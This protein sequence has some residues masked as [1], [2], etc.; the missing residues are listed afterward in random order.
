M[1][2]QTALVPGSEGLGDGTPLRY[3]K[4]PRGRARLTDQPLPMEPTTMSADAIDVPA[5]S[6]ER[7]P[8][9]LYFLFAT[10]MWERFGFYTAAAIMTLYLQ[11]GGFGWTKDQ[12]TSL[13]SNYLMFV[14]AT[15]L[16]RRLAGRPDARLPPTVLIGGRLLHRGLYAA[17]ARIGGDVLRRSRPDLRRQRV[18][19]AQHLDDGR[20]PLPARQSPEGFGVQHLLHGDQHRRLLAPVVAEG[21]LQ[22][23]AGSETIQAVSRLTEKGTR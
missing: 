22:W 16:D 8:K 21:L 20:Q 1:E 9:E 10:E 6:K 13:W 7:H 12:A 14:Y 23:V 4:E 5:V 2:N 17:R 15:P 19:Q 18:L 3:F 11:R